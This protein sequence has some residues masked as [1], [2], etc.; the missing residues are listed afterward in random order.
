MAVRHRTGGAHNDGYAI[1]KTAPEHRASV[2]YG[3]S[4]AVM[5]RPT[6]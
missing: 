1:V 3:M 2:R 5:T 4:V 6:G